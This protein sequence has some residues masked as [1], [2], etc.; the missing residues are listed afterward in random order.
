[1]KK[2]LI[3]KGQSQY[4]LLRYWTDALAVGFEKQ[5]IDVTILD[6]KI[7]DD[8]I[9]SMYLQE[10]YEA[11]IAFNGYMLQSGFS[12]LL[13]CPYIYIL[14]DHPIDHIARIN[15]LKST[16]ILTI[17][18]RNDIYSLDRFCKMPNYVYMLP[19][20]AQEI[21]AKKYDKTIDVLFS[22]T[23]IDPESCKER[24]KENEILLKLFEDV[25]Q[26]CL[27]QSESYYIDEI[28]KWLKQV[29]KRSVDFKVDT[30]TPLI[31]D[32]G[33]YIYAVRRLE[34]LEAIL[35]SGIEV[36]VYGNGWDNSVIMK[37]DNAIIRSGVNYWK[38]QE[39]MRYSKIILNIAGIAK[40]GTH[41]RV[42]A[43]MAAQSV[44]LTNETPY[45]KEL[46]EE[47][48]E[49]LFYN[50]NQIEEVPQ[51]IT[52]ILKNESELSRVS[53]NAVQAIIDKHT[54]NERAKALIEI[55]EAEIH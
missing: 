39:I 16:D 22:G 21:T 11:V 25:T 55:L 30:F 10:E 34:V 47:N 48:E 8:H 40:D 36:Y 13:K 35:K 6:L 37:Y 27:S 33:R 31:S 54:W 17:V 7:L 28:D 38:L 29:Y 51:K 45:L 5:G 18:D 4:N 46:F 41:E 50:F 19:H 49:L 42:F 3:L 12:E 14:I 1:M 53:H 26:K 15:Q 43:G 24:W 52:R 44:V 20:A 9:L 23:Y 32:I 2:I